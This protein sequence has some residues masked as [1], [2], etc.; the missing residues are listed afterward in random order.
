MTYSYPANPA[1][2]RFDLVKPGNT[3]WE[4]SIDKPYVVNRNELNT[5]QKLLSMNFYQIDTI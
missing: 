5:G 3:P 4:L 2:I 1:G